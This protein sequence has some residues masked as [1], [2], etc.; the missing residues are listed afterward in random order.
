MRGPER[1]WL[2]G[3]GHANES[4]HGHFGQRLGLGLAEALTSA[5]KPV[6]CRL[7]HTHLHLRMLHHERNSGNYILLSISLN[8][9]FIFDIVR[10]HFFGS[11]SAAAITFCWWC[12]QR[13]F[14]FPSGAKIFCC[15]MMNKYA[16]M[17]AQSE[18]NIL[19]LTTAILAIDPCAHMPL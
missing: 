12:R 5:T 7:A 11:T 17:I 8:V 3:S 18:M 4:I 10:V 13:V 16:C 1:F 15:R 2:A 6:L 19:L 9:I 14:S